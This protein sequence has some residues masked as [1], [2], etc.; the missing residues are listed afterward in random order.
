MTT[1][2]ARPIDNLKVALSSQKMQRWLGGQIHASLNRNATQMVNIVIQAAG[3]NEMLAKCTP[4][5]VLVNLCLAAQI[6]LVPNTAL[7]HA[8]LV[9]FQNSRKRG[10]EWIK[11]TE[12]Q[13]VI[14]Y[15]GMVKLA[16]DAAGLVVQA[17]PVYECDEFDYNLAAFPPVKL[18]KPGLGRGRT[19]NNLTY[20]YCLMKTKDGLVFGE[21]LTRD[22]V[23]ARQALSKNK[24]S[25]NS[26]WFTHTA[27][28]WRKTAVRH[29]MKLAP[30]GSDERLERAI[31]AEDMDVSGASAMDIIDMADAPEEARD[32]RAAVEEQQQRQALAPA[33]QDEAMKWIAEIQTCTDMKGRKSVV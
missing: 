32:D 27:E 19:V 11:V 20:A 22:D 28:M 15:Q 5:S 2:L 8:W 10:N 14:G 21:V 17:H 13:L 18:H 26:P 24:D 30:K 9:P 16:H 3:Q 33:Q 7:G 4:Q 31:E 23:L 25:K 1:A 12:A 29:A 6:G